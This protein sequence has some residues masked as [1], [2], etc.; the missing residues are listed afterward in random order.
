MTEHTHI[1]NIR[2][3]GYG[4]FCSFFSLFCKFSTTFWLYFHYWSTLKIN[5]E[6]S[7]AV[8]AHPWNMNQLCPPPHPS[9]H[10]SLWKCRHVSPRFSR[11]AS[12]WPSVPIK[13]SGSPEGAGAKLPSEPLRLPTHH[14]LSYKKT[15]REKGRPARRALLGLAG[16]PLLQ[17]LEGM[18]SKVASSNFL[19]PDAGGEY[20]WQYPRE[21][22]K[23][24]YLCP[25]RAVGTKGELREVMLSSVT[26]GLHLD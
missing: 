20:S 1:Q 23:S 24:T 17:P 13:S 9:T 11:E 12:W 25:Q 6:T 2:A 4:L 26:S 18:V 5:R 8:Q 10:H 14:S 22:W 21:T 7:P 16:V 19:I 15:G 3:M